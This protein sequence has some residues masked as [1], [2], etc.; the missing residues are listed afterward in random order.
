RGRE[1][2]GEVLARL[3]RSTSVTL[4]GPDVT[5]IDNSGARE[6]AGERF[7]EVLRKAMAFSDLS[8]MI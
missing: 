1:S 8:D 2:R 7:A 3:A 5:S 4:S 6:I